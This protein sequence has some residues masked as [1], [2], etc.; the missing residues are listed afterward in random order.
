M[1]LKE[2]IDEIFDQLCTALLKLSNEQYS[3]QSKAIFNATIGQ[4]V[5]HIIELF[6]C[7]DKGYMTG[8]VNYEKRERNIDLEMDRILAVEKLSLI[9][10][11]IVRSDKV[12]LLEANYSEH[13][14]NTFFVPTNYWREIIYNLEHTVHH[15]ALIRV[16]LNELADLAVP[17]EFGVAASTIK[18]K[19][20]CAQ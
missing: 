11:S 15:M 8:I 19:R 4:H 18:H 7:L 12:L 5:R 16:A 1:E 17:Q 9:N 3:R 14:E 10:N 20:K 6:L 2:S 13:T